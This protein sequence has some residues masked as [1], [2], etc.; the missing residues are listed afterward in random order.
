MKRIFTLLIALF[1]THTAAAQIGLEA[2]DVMK[3]HG[4]M[5]VQVV[6]GNELKWEQAGLQ[7]S[8]YLL[9]F[10]INAVKVTTKDGSKL[11]Q[12]QA[13]KFMLETRPRDQ[14]VFLNLPDLG[15][16]GAAWA[17]DAS[18]L[19]KRDRTT[20]WITTRAWRDHEEAEKKRAETDEKV[21]RLLE[22]LP[23]AK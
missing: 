9:S 16:D 15:P 14:W 17:A 5:A 7:V 22:G 23:G 2:S 18:V 19:A 20:L 8:A 13:M 21:K 12:E 3:R 11:D 4:A 6:T 10:K 1:L